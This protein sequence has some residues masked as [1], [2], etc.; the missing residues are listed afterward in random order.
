MKTVG[1]TFAA[2]LPP[3]APSRLRALGMG[4]AISIFGLASVGVA[5]D[6]HSED[7]EIADFDEETDTLYGYADGRSEADVFALVA[8]TNFVAG[9]DPEDFPPQPCRGL[10]SNW[11]NWAESDASESEKQEHFRTLLGHAAK[12]S[13]SFHIVSDAAGDILSISPVP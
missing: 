6:I 4:V 10:A 7:V 2:A 1:K 9:A 3:I 5:Q 13:C 12:Q 11:N 8:G